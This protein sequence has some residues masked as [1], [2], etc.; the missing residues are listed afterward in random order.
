MSN[1]S[2]SPATVYSASSEYG[3]RWAA[4]N[5]HLDYFG[6]FC[7]WSAAGADKD[8]PWL[9]ISLPIPYIVV[10]VYIMQRC[11]FLQYPKVV[12][13]RTSNDDETWQDVV[14]A[15][16]ISTRYSSYDGSVSIWFSTTFSSRYWE[17]SI[18]SYVRHPF[19]KCDLLGYYS[20]G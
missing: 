6:E 12:D 20:P 18:V 8:Y 7:G 19:M 15:E 2:L 10:G 11:D 16:D 14:I 3:S 1:T 4:Q 17:I 9:K 5:A 13:V